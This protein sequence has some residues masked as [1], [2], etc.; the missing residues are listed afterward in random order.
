MHLL[1]NKR[2]IYFYLFS[3]F[4]LTTIINQNLINFFRECF[5][6]KQI[7][8]KVSSSEIKKNIQMNTNYL[9]NKNIIFLDKKNIFEA[10][11]DLNYLENIS[12][13]KNYH[14]RLK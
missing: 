7:E 9:N 3:L 2:K 10:L 5:L 8:I 12:V 14:Q 11:S 4:I 1:I 6:I 13:K